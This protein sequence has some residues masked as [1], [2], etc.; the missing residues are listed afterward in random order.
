MNSD[1]SKEY[2]IAVDIGS[3]QKGHFGWADT[4]GKS[5]DTVAGF[6][7]RID[8]R[9]YFSLGIEA[10]LFIPLSGKVEDFTHKR[11]FD[12]KHP[13]SASAGACTT[14]IT[15]GFLARILM[16]FAQKGI[17][18]TTD[19]DTW[20]SQKDNCI[21]IWEAFISGSFTNIEQKSSHIKDAKTALIN[22]YDYDN[23]HCIDL[24]H[25]FPIPLAVGLQLGMK[26]S[27]ETKS[28]LVVKGEK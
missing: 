8:N 18:I 15:L 21:L 5:G 26:V 3:P 4:E 22:Y 13:W 17:A 6:L 28:C 9:T 25:Y 1:S 23:C 7:E 20:K 27:N 24:R 10:P 16:L 11:D 19:L 12:G 2:I 14:A